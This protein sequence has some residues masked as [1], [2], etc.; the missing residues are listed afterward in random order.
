MRQSPLYLLALIFS[1]LLMLPM[2]PTAWEPYSYIKPIF[3]YLGFFFSALALLEAFHYYTSTKRLVII[4]LF[5][6]TLLVGFINGGYLYLFLT[7]SLIVGA[8]NIDY[9][10]ILKVWLI[11]CISFCMF[12][13]FGTLMGFIH[14]TSVDIGDREVLFES[15]TDRRDFGY[16]WATDFAYHVM[17]ILLVYWILKNG[18]LKKV[19]LICYVLISFVVYSLTDARMAV[20]G[21]CLIIICAFY[22]NRIKSKQIKIGKIGRFLF[23]VSIPFFAFISFYLVK[24]FDPM[25]PGWMVVDLLMTGRLSISSKTIEEAGIPLLG[26][27]FEF[28]GQSQTQNEQGIEGFY[29]YIDCSYVQSLVINGII[30]TVLFVLLF[31][32]ICRASYKRQDI[33]LAIAV[34]IAGITGMI[35]QYLFALSYCPLLLA[36]TSFHGCLSHN[37]GQTSS[38]GGII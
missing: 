23:T 8:I 37:R 18:Y 3:K 16:G 25:S 21:M 35:A 28:Y 38:N 27:K 11:I 7:F 32:F 26:Q 13:V 22:C 24:A 30:L 5:L 1:V 10:K 15:I 2:L 6:L 33:V 4:C 36:L 14:E 17:S 9:K 19:E 31:V 12:S 29:N 34:V 20:G